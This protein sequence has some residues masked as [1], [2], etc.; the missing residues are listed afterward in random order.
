MDGSLVKKFRQ[1]AFSAP[2]DISDLPNGVY[3]V[4]AI[5]GNEKARGK[6]VICR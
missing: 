1:V 3:I 6:L 5:I 2:I 4:F